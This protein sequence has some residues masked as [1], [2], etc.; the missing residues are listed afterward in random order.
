MKWQ[1]KYQKNFQWHKWF[2]WYPIS[3][4][5][6]NYWLQWIWRRRHCDF[7]ECCWKYD[8]NKPIDV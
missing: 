3:W 1:S 4:G 2:A 7:Y 8:I 5:N 6:Y